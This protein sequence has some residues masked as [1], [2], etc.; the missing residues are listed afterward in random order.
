MENRNGG[1]IS[2]V[3][4]GFPGKGI[5]VIFMEIAGPFHTE[6]RALFEATVCI[7]DVRFS[8]FSLE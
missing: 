6:V 7:E 5:A 4:H 2:E 3:A 1:E 8:V